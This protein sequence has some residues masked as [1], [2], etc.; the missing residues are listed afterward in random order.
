M[1]LTGNFDK[2]NQ[3]KDGDEDSSG[4]LESYNSPGHVRNLC[5]VQLDGKRTFLNYAYLIA[6]NHV[7]EE[8][9]IVLTYSTHIITLKGQNLEKL[10]DNLRF[11]LPKEIVAIE[12]RYSKTKNESEIIVNE[13]EILV[14]NS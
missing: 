9:I 1:T 14:L 8:N 6:G 4:N 11:H 12:N 2:L 13:I 5:F 10:F 7:S 3:R